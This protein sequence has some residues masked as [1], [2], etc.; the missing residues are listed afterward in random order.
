MSALVD[1]PAGGYRYLPAVFQYSSGVVAMPGHAIER[2]RFD[3]LAPLAEGFARVERLLRDRARPLSAFCACELRSPEPFSEQGFTEFNR[4]YVKTLERWGLYRD[5]ANPVA[6]T[7]VCPLFDAP[8]EPSLYAFSFTV[9]ATARSAPDF[10]VAGG[11][12]ASEGSGT[13]RERIVRLGDTSP[14]GLRDKV[15]FVVAAMERRLAA[16]AVA[17]R[18]ASATQAYTIHDI[19]ALVRDGIA[20]RG[21][22]AHGL[23]WHVA[24]PPVIDIEFEMDVRATSVEHVLAP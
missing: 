19:G 21:A 16:L 13:Y 2:V 3:R 23:T 4:G 22:A 5:G 15:S 10:V 20:A 18:D 7:N 1:V 12:E 11:G 9:P 14:E 17:W 8:N 24:R 6:R